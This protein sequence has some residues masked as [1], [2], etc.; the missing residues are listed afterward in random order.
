VSGQL[1]RS[2]L[3]AAL[4]AEREWWKRLHGALVV[5]VAQK[6]RGKSFLFKALQQTKLH[7]VRRRRRAQRGAQR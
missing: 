1:C 4:L 2:N 6:G 7:G 3:A 5:D